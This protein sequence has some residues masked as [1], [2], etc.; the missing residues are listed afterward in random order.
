MRLSVAAIAICL[1]I[2]GVSAAQN[3]TAAM[4]KPTN[5]PAQPLG[6]ALEALAKQ[7]DLQVIYRSDLVGGLQTAGAV[8]VFTPEQALGRGRQPDTARDPGRLSDTRRLA[9]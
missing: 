9:G 3:A 2:V 1:A 6:A 8:G 7:R 4:R 5:I